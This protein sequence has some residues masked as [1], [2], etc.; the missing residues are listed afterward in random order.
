MV[1]LDF[2]PKKKKI[3]LRVRDTRDIHIE[4]IDGIGFMIERESDMDKITLSL[5]FL[6]LVSC[7]YY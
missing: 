3:T 7:V 5:L 2:S 1:W 6:F 4:K